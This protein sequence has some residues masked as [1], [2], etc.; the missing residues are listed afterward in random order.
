MP[1]TPSKQPQLVMIRLSHE[2]LSP[3]PE[4][5]DGYRMR[6]A[7]KSDR[8]SYAALFKKVFPDPEMPFDSL[9]ERSLR[10]GFLV[11][12]DRDDVVRASAAAAIFPKEQ[13]P[14]GASLQWV[15]SDPDRRGVGIGRAVVHAASRRL[16][17]SGQ[18]YAFLSTDDFRLAAISLYLSLGWRPLLTPGI[19]PRWAAVFEALGQPFNAADWP[20]E[21]PRG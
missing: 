4:P 6:C 14:G 17:D 7:V 3:A 21:P 1:A 19:E 16:C 8:E 15:M 5:A 13:H 9:A 12:V 2:P 11:V 20:K 10:N 18:S